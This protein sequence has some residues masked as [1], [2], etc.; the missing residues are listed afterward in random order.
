MP[1]HNDDYGGIC[2][3]AMDAV[4]KE[5]MKNYTD[6]ELAEMTFSE[7][8]TALSNSI[9]EASA[10][11]ERLQY[12]GKI[13][14]NGHHARQAIVKHAVAELFMRWLEFDKFSGNEKG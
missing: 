1:D 3:R 8:E 14:G 10:L 2:F 5:F 7:A 13:S 12:A 4:G 11:I 6:K 9:Y